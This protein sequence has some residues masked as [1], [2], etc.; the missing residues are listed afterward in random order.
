MNKVLCEFCGKAIPAARLKALPDTTTCVKCS[1]TE[2]Y[3][4]EEI[5]GLDVSEDSERANMNLEDYDDFS[6]SH[7]FGSDD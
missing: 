6:S 4:R 3:S 5:L 1:Q 7:S 2:P